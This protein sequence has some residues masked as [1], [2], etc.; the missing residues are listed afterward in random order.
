MGPK[1]IH[2]ATPID[3]FEGFK[4]YGKNCIVLG[5][6]IVVKTVNKLEEPL[7]EGTR[8]YSTEGI[9]FQLTYTKS[10]LPDN[11]FTSDMPC[12]IVES[13]SPPRV[14]SWMS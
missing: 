3:L 8:R 10:E 7:H 9:I 2:T 4:W 11:H 6:D 12:F 1:P 5:N 14:K 13:Q